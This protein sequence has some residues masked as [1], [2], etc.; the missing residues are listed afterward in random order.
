MERRP[1]PCG[2][3]KL[4]TWQFDA[5]RIA[6]CRTCDDCH[7]TRMAMYRPEVLNN[8]SYW[9]DEPIDED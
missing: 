2:S 6:L 9:C 7:D 5:R 3:G 4:S 1:C 8:P